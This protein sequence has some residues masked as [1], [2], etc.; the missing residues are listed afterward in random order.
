MSLSPDVQFDFHCHALTDS[1]F[2]VLQF[3]GNEKL[4]DL[5]QFEIQLISQSAQHNTDDLLSSDC[6]LD[7]TVYGENRSINGIL[8][9][10]K[11]L[12]P[13]ENGHLFQATLVPKLWR[14]T[15]ITTN[16]VYLGQDIQ[17]T[18]NQILD[19]AN[20]TNSDYDLSM[21]NGYRKWD[22]RCQ[23]SENHYDFLKRITEREGIY[24]Y[25]DQENNSEKVVFCDLKNQHPS[26]V[27]TS[28]YTPLN[29][30]SFIKDEPALYQWIQNNQRTPKTITIKDYNNDQPSVDLYAKLTIDSKGFGEIFRYCDN[31]LDKEEA[32]R[33]V[34]IR[35]EEILTDK[36]QFFGSSI[37]VRMLPAQSF[38]L[39][40]HP[41]EALNDEFSCI[42]VNHQGFS[43]GLQF[44]HQQDELP[45]SNTIK[46]LKADVQFRPEQKTEKPRFYGVFNA[47]VDCEGDGQYAHLD[48][49]GRYKVILPFDRE[50]RNGAQASWWI[51]MAQPNA[52]ENSGMHFPLLKGAEV[53][54]SFIGGDPDR[55]II[56]GAV[57]NAAK[58]SI[59]REDNHTVN[60]IKTASN[61]IIELEDETD[62]ERIKLFS[63]NSNTYL[64]LGAANPVDANGLMMITS[65]GYYQ[66][67]GGG[68][69]ITRVTTPNLEGALHTLS[70]DHDNDS[71]TA[72]QD[73]AQTG[74]IASSSTST[75]LDGS[76]SA[77]DLIDETKIFVFNQA[78]D[79]GKLGSAITPANERS[80]NYF[81]YREHGEKYFWNDGNTHTFGGAKD[82][83]YGNGY[84]ISYVEYES[85]TT[86]DGSFSEDRTFSS[87]EMDAML[88]EKTIG[89]TYEYQNGK[90]EAVH[91]GD[92][93]E[94]HEGF[95]KSVHN[96]SS[97]ERSY[98]PAAT[99]GEAIAAKLEGAVHA[100]DIAGKLSGLSVDAS[101]Q[102]VKAEIDFSAVAL[103]FSGA[104]KTIEHNEGEFDQK[105][106][107]SANME[108][109][110]I[111]L[112]ALTP[113]PPPAAT[114]TMGDKLSAWASQF[115]EFKGID[116][117]IDAPTQLEMKMTG[118]ILFSGTRTTN[119]L[120][121]KPAGIEIK[122]STSTKVSGGTTKLEGTTTT[123]IKGATTTVEGT[124]A[125]TIKG[126][127]VKVGE[128]AGTMNL[129]GGA[130]TLNIKGSVATMK[131]AGTIQ[132]QATI[133]QLG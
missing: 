31:L 47:I 133:L 120:Q 18:I 114:P 69:Q 65:G 125:V 104:L 29:G 100:T 13:T 9:D 107:I 51:P 112:K 63:P 72:D 38:E 110:V 48:D 24:F 59:V 36:E 46:A 68:Y 10:F 14:L 52:G 88:I 4:G 50:D 20:L 74:G 19:E 40:G 126:T 129:G 108:S 26:S 66:E 131:T 32:E 124:T 64:H 99:A 123:D 91:V 71:E 93:D 7:L 98:G 82:F 79:T 132:M 121:V 12:S 67:I 83:G 61:N 15:Q 44:I 57:P 95:A 84:E 17:Q 37:D 81:T 60:K 55:P 23:F 94:Y 122:G 41:F 8:S 22:Y 73:Q 43:P 11:Y 34:Q 85:N 78:D 92:V 113:P 116:A 105:S 80:G 45:Y 102:I 54:L 58:P 16:E 1:T 111:T 21:L 90:N 130:T 56:T 49:R 2:Q 33:L 28:I 115:K 118:A 96:G 86:W 103:S 62:S 5:F 35:S 39:T 109:P 70:V 6:S 75:I 42:E 128:T 127:T 117:N 3:S 97:N 77:M 30:K 27:T 101:V 106:R 89:H 76:D 53:L 87:A 119:Y 25:F